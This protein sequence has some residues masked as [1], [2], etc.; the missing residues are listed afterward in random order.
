MVSIKP[1]SPPLPTACSLPFQP[2]SGSQTSILISESLLGLASATTRQKAGR[3][4]YSDERSAPLN[5][6]GGPTN[7]PAATL[8]TETMDT[9][10][11]FSVERCSQKFCGKALTQADMNSNPI[12]TKR[13]LVVIEDLLSVTVSGLRRNG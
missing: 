7:V 8:C 13:D 5:G 9:A 11:I 6:A 2:A 4:L 3:L 1:A 12:R 10:G